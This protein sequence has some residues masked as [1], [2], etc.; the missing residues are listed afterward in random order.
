MNKLSYDI[1]NV[2]ALSMIAYGV[3]R[4]FGADIAMIVTGAAGLLLNLITLFVAVRV[5]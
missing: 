3:W 1:T 2:I 5:K 4:Y